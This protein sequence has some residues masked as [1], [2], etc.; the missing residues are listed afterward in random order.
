MQREIL[1]AYFCDGSN[2]EGCWNKLAE[3]LGNKLEGNSPIRTLRRRKEDN[4]KMDFEHI[5][6]EGADWL[7][8]ALERERCRAV[9]RTVMNLRFQ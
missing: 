8:L 2:C 7:H 9:V 4:I 5:R 6:S 1:L 3:F